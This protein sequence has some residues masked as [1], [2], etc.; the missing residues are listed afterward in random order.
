MNPF[1]TCTGQRKAGRDICE[2][3]EQEKVWDRKSFSKMIDGGKCVQLYMCCHSKT[4]KDTRNQ[5]AI[6]HVKP[7]WK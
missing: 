6:C 2:S 4:H 5:I 1:T 3:R 7:Q